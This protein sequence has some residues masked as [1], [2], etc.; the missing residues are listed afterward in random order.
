M[1]CH[2]VNR[3]FFNGVARMFSVCYVVVRFSERFIALLCGC[4]GVLGV[5]SVLLCGN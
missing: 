1:S 3:M 5:F 2:M 4:Q